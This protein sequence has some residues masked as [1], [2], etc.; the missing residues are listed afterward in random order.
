M[1]VLRPGVVWGRDN[2]WTARLGVQA[3]KR[4]W[5]RIGA[6]A[7]LP[8]TYVENCAQAIVLSAEKVEAVGQTLN[9]ID[10][11]AP[12]QRRYAKLLKW[13]A[14]PPPSIVPMPLT[15]MR[16]VAGTATV[17]NRV[18]LESTRVLLRR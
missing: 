17:V 10:D 15:L 11:E 18:M 12:T 7:R 4:V 16:L 2:L 14:N 6:W 13:Q 3:S 8:L 5:V 9:V 1:T